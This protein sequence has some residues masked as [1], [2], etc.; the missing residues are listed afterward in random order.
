VTVGALRRPDRDDGPLA[1]RVLVR[2]VTSPQLEG[3]CRR[4]L[5]AIAQHLGARLVRLDGEHAPSVYAT[6]PTA[7]QYGWGRPW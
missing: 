4:Q 7:S 1:T 6:M 5:R 3:E 2:V